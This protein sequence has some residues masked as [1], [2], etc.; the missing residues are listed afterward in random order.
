M[1]KVVGNNLTSIFNKV[2]NV[3]NGINL[4]TDSVNRYVNVF[5]KL[6][7]KQ[8]FG[9]GWEQFLNGMNA[10]NANVASYFQELAKQGASAKANIQ[11]VY[12]AILDG[13][14]HGVQNV[15]S[16][17]SAFKTV[18]PQNQQAFAR[19]VGQTNAQ[20]G[21]YLGNLNGATASMKGYTASLVASTAKT[22]A[23]R[24][25]TM[26]LNSL[27]WTGVSFVIS[28]LIKW[29]SDLIVTEEEAI[30]KSQEVASSFKEEKNTLK[31]LKQEYLDIVDSNKS[32][33]E[34][35]KELIEW[36]KKLIE[37]YGL[38][39]EAINKVTTARETGLS[40]INEEIYNDAQNAIAGLENYDKAVE[41]MNS[42]W[43]RKTR[44][45]IDF[46]YWKKFEKELN[47][48][49]IVIGKYQGEI[50]DGFSDF[51]FI[52]TTVDDT[53]ESINQLAS[54]ITYLETQ[55]FDDEKMQRA[56]DIT[57]KSLRK[58]YDDAKKA[59]EDYSDIYTQ[60]T[61]AY[62][63]TYLYEYTQKSGNAISDVTEK[64]FG[65]W[66]ENLLALADD[67]EP[68]RK[69]LEEMADDLFPDYADSA[70]KANDSNKSSLSTVPKLSTAYS[71]LASKIT[72]AQDAMEDFM[73]VAGKFGQVIGKAIS[74][75]ALSTEE[76]L[77]LLKLAP[78]LA[79]KFEKVGV[80]EWSAPSDVLL[81]SA[82]EYGNAN[83]PYNT[84]YQ[85]SL[86][87][88]NRLRQ[89][90]EIQ[91]Q[92]IADLT[93]NVR[94]EDTAKRLYY[95]Q[96]SLEVNKANLETE[97]NALKELEKQKSIYGDLVESETYSSQFQ[98]VE[99]KVTEHNNNLE[100]LQKAIDN[101]T[102]GT[103]ISSDEMIKLVDAFPELKDKFTVVAGGFNVETKALE[104]LKTA[105]IE[106]RKEFIQSQ[107]EKVIAAREE[108]QLLVK[109]FDGE[110]KLMKAL[111]W[112]YSNSESRLKEYEGKLQ[113]ASAYLEMFNAELA[114]YDVWEDSLFDSESSGSNNISNA[115]QSQIDY[116]STLIEAIEIV[117]DRRIELLE[118][119]KDALKEKND[120]EQRELDL[121]E[122]K[123]N[124]DKARK[125][126]VF[127]Y[128]E[129]K[130]LVQKEN[131]KA[132][133]DAEKELADVERE[134][135][136]AEY[137]KLIETLEDYKE[138]FSNMESDIK[139]NLTVEKAKNALGTDEEG[140][141]HL[142][143]KVAESIQKGLTGAV[144]A[145]DREDNKDNPYYGKFKTVTLDDV[146]KSMGATV[147][148]V[149][150]KSMMA[151][152][153]PNIP[154]NPYKVDGTVHTDYVVNNNGTTTF[155]A[156]FNITGT[157]NPNEVA[158]I[159]KQNISGLIKDMYNKEK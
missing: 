93:G 76:M 95:L 153:T 87:T 119:E 51:S 136:T 89:E 61:S 134:I 4:S 131:T 116:Y 130:G 48:F 86:N 40:V 66:K 85:N 70:D 23:L 98:N 3:T 11:G 62:A 144:L 5:N 94:N 92:Q 44:S 154:V 141:L 114:K 73:G 71:D 122:A 49:G 140:L 69:E 32:E 10:Q 102:D 124:L 50:G 47:N 77:E 2:Q 15:R 41:K 39:E 90:I 112:L 52:K 9:H 80:D 1:F 108:Q 104:E 105:T 126:T 28:G 143:E 56:A 6:N 118:K 21:T 81:Q 110:I 115:L 19:A 8:A 27:L 147:N 37:Q 120:E 137:D 58:V 99:N 151:D 139:D 26:A 67:S 106:E 83:N 46:D 100:A 155:N 158:N 117:A 34:K 138:P 79:T 64:N 135:K 149:E 17:I 31:D 109:I 29:V 12:A 33:I 7:S 91:K 25:A 38:E 53:E 157:A 60:G 128:E 150:F 146:L 113:K 132:I 78:E 97:L 111:P 96:K 125:Q 24:A 68:I 42:S 45:T 121:I 13:N 88:V 57:I 63:I 123:N 20:L 22:I 65:E 36:K 54:A 142:D 133:R 101:V 59:V 156:T 16:V 30:Q 14:T 152:L 82:T 107:R 129:G 35:N 145:K 55:S 103:A 159:V 43:S 148:S 72:K 84:D 127:V 74:G 75:A 18:N